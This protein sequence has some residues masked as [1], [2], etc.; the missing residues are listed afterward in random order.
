[1]NML[2]IDS[3]EAKAVKMKQFCILTEEQATKC[4]LGRN[5]LLNQIADYIAD[6]H[7]SLIEQSTLYKELMYNIDSRLQIV[8][9]LDNSIEKEDK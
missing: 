6:N 3:D 4:M 9:R 7:L 1:M 2:Y 8:D 5:F